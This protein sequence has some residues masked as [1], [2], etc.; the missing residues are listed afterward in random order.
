MTEGLIRLAR[1][2]VE[3]AAPPGQAD[4]VIGDLDERLRR[5]EGERGRTRAALWYWGEA[6]RSIG[7]LLT[8][9]ERWR[10]GAMWESGRI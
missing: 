4:F 6:L 3:L 9:P 5:V 8:Y 1:K 10:G 7:P 2:V